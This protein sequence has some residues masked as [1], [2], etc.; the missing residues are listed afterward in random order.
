MLYKSSHKLSSTLCD[1]ETTVKCKISQ[2]LE[3][4]NFLWE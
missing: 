1:L 2:Q 3:V 4:E